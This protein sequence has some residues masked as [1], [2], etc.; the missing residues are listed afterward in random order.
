M[1]SRTPSG[2]AKKRPPRKATVKSHVLDADLVEMRREQIVT[3]AVELFSTQGYDRTTI[4]EIAR[5]AQISVGLIY[6]YARTK[7]DVLF[8]TLLSVL[9]SYKQEIPEVEPEDG[10]LVSLW[11]ALYAYGRVIDRRRSAAVLAYR[12]TQSLPM[13]QRR[14]IMELET[15]TNELLAKRIQ[16]CVRAGTFR[17]M[18]VDLAVY[19]IVM[20]AHAWALKHWRLAQLTSLDVYLKVG[21]DSF[22][23]AWATP[24]GMTVFEKFRQIRER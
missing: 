2:S 18:N 4:L 6:Q 14:S 13:A 15:E 11:K 19:Q 5:K 23:R 12:S 16:A 1:T 10:P 22:V 8:L 9:H 21:F 3:A 24:E 17:D 7:E 20:H